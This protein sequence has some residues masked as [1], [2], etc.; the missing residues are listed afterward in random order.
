MIKLQSMEKKLIY[1]RVK[2]F[3]NFQIANEVLF[4]NG[5]KYNL[6]NPCVQ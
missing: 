3:H 5:N 4:V 2:A 6:I 1:V